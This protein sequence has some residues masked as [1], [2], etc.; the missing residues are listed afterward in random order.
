[1]LHLHYSNQV[2]QLVD[3][4]IHTLEHQRAA[5]VVDVFTPTCLVVPNPQVETFLKFTIARR[6][7]SAANLHCQFLQD[8]LAGLRPHTSTPIRLLDKN[9]IQ[10]MLL[11]LL[12]RDDMLGD[13]H[14]QPL[15][16]Y[17]AAAG[18][19]DDD[20]DRRRFQL[21]AHV[22]RLFEEY[23]FTR[24]EMLQAW[25]QGSTLHSTPY[26]ATED[27]QR[28]LWLALFGAE[29]E[30]QRLS[31][32]SG[33]TWLS[34]PEML[35][36]GLFDH[37]QVPPHVHIFGLSYVAR[38]F[39][40]IFVRLAQ[41]TEV[42]MYTLY[43][44]QVLE[45]EQPSS[46][47]RLWGRPGHESRHWLLEHGGGEVASHDV[48]P[49]AAGSTLLHRLQRDI[50]LRRTTCASA[51]ASVADDQSL[52]ILAC[53]GIRRE[54]EIIANEIWTLIMHEEERNNDAITHEPLRFHDI[55]IL[56]N[57]QEREAYQTHIAAVFKECYD[58]P[59]TLIDVPAA[60][61]SRFVE[62]V[63]LLLAL[64]FGRFT[65]QELLRLLTHPAFLCRLP[66]VEAEEWLA[67]CEQLTIVHGA[68]HQ[69][70]ADTYITRDLFN[71]EQ[72][73]R[74]LLLGT[75][76]S[77]ARSGETRPFELGESSYLPQESGQDRLANAAS[78]ALLVR[79]LIADARFCQSA[80]LSLA[81]WAT[82]LS[83][84]LTTYL[85]APAQE[86]E[87]YVSRCLQI[88]QRLEELDLEAH[89]V[90]YRMAY[91]YVTSALQGLEGGHG[92]Y[93]YGGVV[94]S[95]FQ[96]MR[97]IPF[98]VVFI[99][100]M[101]EGKFP[102]MQRDDALDLRLARR[103]SGDVSSREQ[104]LYMFLETLLSTRQ[105]LYVSYV[106]R[107]AQ[108]G[109][110][111]QPSSVIQEL[112]S[113]LG[114]GAASTD[115]LDQLTLR[116]P[117]QRYDRRYFPAWFPGHGD[118][119]VHV[120]PAAR[121]E[122]Q[123]LALH[124]DLERFCQQHGRP[125][126][127]L[128][129]LRA[130]LAPEQWQRL[131]GRLGLVTVADVPTGT[132]P[133]TTR[134]EQ[135]AVGLNAVSQAIAEQA[136]DEPVAVGS[137]T[138]TLAV[139]IASLRQFLLCPLQG[140]AR[141]QLG[142]RE[143]EE[144][145]ILARQ[146]EPFTPPALVATMLLRQVFMEKLARDAQEGVDVPFATIYDARA[147]HLELAGILPTGIFLEAA[148]AK[149]LQILARWQ[150]NLGQTKLGPIDTPKVLR[151]G[152]AEEHTA[153][154]EL[155]PSVMVDVPLPQGGGTSG[156]LRVELY[157]R[158]EAV[159]QALPGSLTLVRAEQG[160][161]RHFLPGFLDY[162]FLTLA[163]RLDATS[164]HTYHT[165][166]NPNGTLQVQAL[167][168]LT[169][170]EATT[171]LREVL[172]DMLGGPHTYLLPV[173]AVFQYRQAKNDRSLADIVNGLRENPYARYSSRYGPVPYPE[174][175]EPPTEAEGER[176]IARRFGLFFAKQQARG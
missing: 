101:G 88:V 104:D 138:E 48:D 7:G 68:D 165:I 70:H 95:S 46:V 50:L 37:C 144:D 117:L 55:A 61:E 120:L 15:Q 110:E 89:P 23:S 145:D 26:A 96:P 162:V 11:G 53:P 62:A 20:R 118:G 25:T 57:S 113:L 34:L 135:S 143:D 140:W 51:D 131:K 148:R 78:F 102:S 108:T 13:P 100:G 156:S 12:S 60:A 63:E 54:V 31:A 10:S 142:L 27:W 125:F 39:L 41:Q 153:V 91:E 169:P 75:F 132:P 79:S 5:G 150:A 159:C 93:L 172:A 47:M 151:F 99:V 107:E 174:R 129:E 67:W 105:C 85:D 17:L 112:L 90:A 44:C 1:M 109:E 33:S 175:Y 116:H 134:L 28:A 58:I 167:Q 115:R 71:W 136:S 86:D 106:C 82:Y 103:Q 30:R 97:P 83:H 123:A 166:V 32:V 66:D 38:V 73:R 24:A 137:T 18:D 163:E 21:S 36:S 4:L 72:G 170:A 146:D 114:P 121:S 52:R 40:Q 69:E 92:E 80:R 84:L 139:S 128:D 147:A 9:I 164:Y 16:D 22:A 35:A 76:M 2:E 65:R 6:T 141:R 42:S 161:P 160:Q 94:V 49:T 149:H 19:R 111:L 77:G 168:P 74:R 56:V 14:F 133:P 176:M 124:D 81:E 64:P 87:R 155:L 45:E 8:F 171:Y 3:T 29:G 158:T 126:P 127:G 43:P 130:Q 122:A 173:E 154:D 59:Y 157:G 98:R 152:R 119:L